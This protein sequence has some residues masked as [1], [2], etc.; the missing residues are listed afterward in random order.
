M[1]LWTIMT[2]A[3]S[4]K[5]HVLFLC[6]GNLCRSPLAEG[7][8]KKKFAERRIN[9]AEV[10]SAGTRALVGEPAAALASKVAAERGVDLSCHVSRQLTKEM[11]K[12]ADIVLAMERG[13]LNEANVIFNEGSGKYHLLSEFGPPHLR[14]HDISDP[15]GGPREY[16]MRTY[17]TI[18]KCL[19][20]LL[21]ELIRIWNLSNLGKPGAESP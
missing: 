11:L 8:L 14:G 5:K 17:D 6:T 18:E 16:F 19:E 20:G 2:V 3:K 4:T 15:Y 12:K 13:H 9:S 21:E 1:F 10:S 7:I